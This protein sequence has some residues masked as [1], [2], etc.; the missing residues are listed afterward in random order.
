MLTNWFGKRCVVLVVE[1][2]A[3]LHGARRRV[4]LIVEREE[5]AARKLLL[6]GPVEGVDREL[7]PLRQ[8]RRRP[9]LADPRRS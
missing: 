6:A 3:R 4:D 2:G 5:R 1:Q 8:A 7:G 9:G